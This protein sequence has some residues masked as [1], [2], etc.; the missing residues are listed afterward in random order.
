MTKDGNGEK[1]KP[2]KTKTKTRASRTWERKPG[3]ERKTDPDA[4]PLQPAAKGGRDML[5]GWKAIA[6]KMGC[7][8]TK[9]IKYKEEL[10]AA[11]VIFKMRIRDKRVS[12]LHVCWC[13]WEHDLESWAR[14]KGA[15]GEII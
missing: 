13:C 3:K 7:G 5:V 1:K 6:A 11:N 12:T 2:E 4:P 9:M 14:L 8:T 10:R 15:A